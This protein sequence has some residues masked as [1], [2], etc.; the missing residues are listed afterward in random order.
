MSPQSAKQASLPPK[1]RELLTQAFAAEDLELPLLPDAASRVLDLCNS[2]ECEAREL[3]DVIQRDQSLAG[4]VLKVSNSAAYAPKE[5][6]VSLAQAVSRLGLSTICEIALAVS[7]KGRVFK[8]PGHAVKVRQMWMHSASTAVY[9]REVARLL[10]HNVEGSFMCGLLHDVGKPFVLQTLVDVSSQYT[11]K[12][13]PSGILELSMD[14]F[15]AEVGTRLIRL[16]G[17]PDWMA[18]AVAHHHT[19]E[20]PQEFQKESQITRMAD[21]L[22][23][24]AL[25][26]S[27]EESDFAA[28]DPVV[29]ALNIYGDE[30]MGLLAHRGKVLEIAEAFV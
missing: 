9:A 19:W 22:S 2:E 30:L 25:D 15:H 4:H 12:P 29:A 10:R 7:L 1:I 28:E 21:L 8:A 26:D 20:T 11:D 14:E 16:W 13:V 17:L 18:E 23:H 27:L 6:I 5:P 3:S 24:W